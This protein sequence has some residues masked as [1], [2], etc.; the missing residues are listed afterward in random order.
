MDLQLNGKRALVTGSSSGIGEGIAKT[1]AKEGAIVIIHGRNQERAS[2]VAEEIKQNGGQAFVA[3]GDLSN[4][5]EAKLVAESTMSAIEGVDILIN[6]AGGADESNGGWLDTPI[7]RWAATYSQNTLAAVRLIKLFVPQMKES[8]WGRV[9]QI[10][11]GVATQPIPVTP[12]YA[13]AKAAIVNLTVSLAKELAETGIT[14]NT[15]SPGTILTGGLERV[16]RGVANEQ[17]WGTDWAELE[18]RAVRELWPNP[19]GRVG[20]VEDIAT[21]VA[22]VASPLA[23]FINGANLRVDGGNIASIN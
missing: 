9:I 17:G 7:E 3:V 2:R 19:T 21:L 23:G 20:R 4:D 11:S 5:E 16:V 22:F 6:N 1:L 10:S 13:A 14:V 8:G 18:K 15:I 12:E